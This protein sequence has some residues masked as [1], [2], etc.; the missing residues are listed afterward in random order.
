M[1]LDRL[2]DD[3]FFFFDLLHDALL[4][5]FFHK[6]ADALLLFRNQNLRDWFL[7]FEE[8]VDVSEVGIRLKTFGVC[9][10]GG[11]GDLNVVIE[12][13]FNAVL[14]LFVQSSKFVLDFFPYFNEL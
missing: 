10:S 13:V 12:G 11:C 8:V 7:V 5:L 2:T 14:V 6:A 9:N 1:H 4:F 3:L